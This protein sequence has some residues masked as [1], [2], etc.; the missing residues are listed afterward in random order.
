MENQF[1]SPD[2]LIASILK[3]GSA[4]GQGWMGLVANAAGPAPLSA[5]PPFW[6]ASLPVDPAH[7]ARMQ[8]EYAERQSRL[9]M[10][11]MSRDAGA[12]PLPAVAAAASGDKRFAAAEWRD[13]PYYDYLKQSYLLAS[14]YLNE[15]VES[16]QVEAHAKDKL[17]F[18]VRQWID[19][20]CPANF[21]A[22]NPEAV[23]LALETNGESISR[24]IANLIADAGKGHISQTDES[25]F[26]VGRN[27]ATTPGAV[28]FENELFQLIQYSATTPSVA[29]RPLVMVPPCINK[30]YILDLQP[31]NS[32]VA[33]AV[34]EGHTVF[35]VSWRNVKADLGHLTWDDYVEA[36][37]IK[38]LGVAQDIAGSDKVNAL[39]FCVGGTLLGTALAVLKARGETPVESVTFLTSFLDFSD[40]GQIGAFVDEQGTQAKEQSIGK[41]G[42]LAGSE[43]AL[44]FS[45]LR[46]N[47]LIWPYVVNNYLKGETPV[48]FDLLYWNSDGTNLPGPMYCWYLRN[49]YLEN[50]LSRPGA[51]TVCGIPVDLGTIALPTF[52][53]G[54]R[55][56]HIVPWKTSYRSVHLLGGE[57]MFVLGASGHIAG[58]INPPAKKKRSYW[59]AAPA[60]GGGLPV[61]A[62]A[63]FGEAVEHP[64]SWWPV[65]SEW[66]AAHKGGEKKA[67]KSLGN[68]RHT[69]IEPAPGRY[70]KE[71]FNE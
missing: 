33:Y 27:L 9:W 21:A 43:L 25:A 17:R 63:W 7:L 57:A 39:G 8:A 36:G 20:S 58:V 10:A 12:A 53:Y 49:T 66:L 16:A 13:V 15:L 48:A 19:A 32:Y 34:A 64:G 69:A 24:G 61:E 40:A 70:V 14:G 41:G 42:L 28:V 50:R 68:R 62:D 67:P 38:A 60:A 52:V 18:A 26:E 59:T 23:R 44:V 22:T 55:E 3:A 5:S 29:K 47:D 37:V 4:M 51:A 56:D 1:E 46:P 45:A 65:W 6:A 35:M 31:E 11:M 30:F 2:A 54:S 71:K